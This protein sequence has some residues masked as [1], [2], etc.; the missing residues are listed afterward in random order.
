MGTLF[1]FVPADSSHAMT[2]TSS[3]RTYL[4]VWGWLA[5]LMLLSVVLSELPIAKATVVLIV[6]L[7]STVKALLVALYYMHLNI[8]RRLLAF[9]AVFP[10]VLISL[11][12]LLVLSS[13]LVKL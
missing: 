1:A 6:L 13:R 4:A 11:A 9:V 2:T 7:L 10:F 3:A 8:D 12:T 5:G